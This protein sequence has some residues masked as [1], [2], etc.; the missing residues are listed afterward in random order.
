MSGNR[1]EAL[2]SGTTTRY[3]YDAAGNLLAEADGSNTIIRYYIYGQGLMSAVTPAG[4]VYCYHFNATGSTVAMTDD[5]EAI[6]NKYA[7]DS[8]GNI[9]SRQEAF[10]QPFQ[11]VGQFGVMMEAVGARTFYYMKARYYDPQ[12]GRFISEDPI[13]FD[14]GDVN[15]YAYVG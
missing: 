2:R 7:Y 12:V 8:F 15:L 11:F 5:S 14:G 4:Q 9:S 13:G 10:S 6:V 3:V 1:L